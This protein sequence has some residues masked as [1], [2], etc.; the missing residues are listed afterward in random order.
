MTF[1]DMK[2]ITMKVNLHVKIFKSWHA[3]YYNVFVPF[4]LLAVNGNIDL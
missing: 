1:F 3:M 4:F 2:Y